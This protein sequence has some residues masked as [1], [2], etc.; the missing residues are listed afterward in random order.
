MR[1]IIGA[2]KNINVAEIGNCTA[3][4]E[5]LCDNLFLIRMALR[6]E[7]CSPVPEVTDNAITVV[8]EEIKRLAEKIDDLLYEREEYEDGRK[9]M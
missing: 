4:L 1:R 7:E 9:Q 3:R 8:E 2:R 6:N 5:M